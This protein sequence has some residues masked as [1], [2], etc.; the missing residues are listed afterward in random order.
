MDMTHASNLQKSPRRGAQF[1]FLVLATLCLLFVMS[2]ASRLNEYARV[3]HELALGTQRIDDAQRHQAELL[4]YRD[5]VQSD[6]YVARVAREELNMVQPGDTVVV[7][8]TAD[9]QEKIAPSADENALPSSVVQ[10]PIW[11]QWFN[12]FVQQPLSPRFS[13]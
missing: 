12:L 1:L 2:Y 4:A 13:R 6:A 8:V 10:T 9:G 5:Y 7:V 3:Q 11:R